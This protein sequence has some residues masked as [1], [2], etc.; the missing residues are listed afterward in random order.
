MALALKE[1]NICN[2][3]LRCQNVKDWHQ[4][5]HQINKQSIHLS[6]HLSTTVFTPKHPYSQDLSCKL[7]AI[8]LDQIYVNI[9]MHTFHCRKLTEFHTTK[10]PI[11]TRS[12]TCKNICKNPKRI[13]FGNSVTVTDYMEHTWCFHPCIKLCKI[14]WSY[15]TLLCSAHAEKGSYTQPPHNMWHSGHHILHDL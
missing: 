11:Y 1:D 5:C 6:L 14:P 9:D 12:P 4:N 10:Q 13:I 15:S 3:V 8:L 7:T 2:D